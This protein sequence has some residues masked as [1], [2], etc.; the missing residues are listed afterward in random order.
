MIDTMGGLKMVLKKTERLGFVC[1]PAYTHK[2]PFTP[3]WLGL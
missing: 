3:K 1:I 2:T